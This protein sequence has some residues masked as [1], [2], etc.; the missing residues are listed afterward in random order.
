M[1]SIMCVF[2]HLQI[3]AITKQIFAH[4]TYTGSPLVCAWLL[5]YRVLLRLKDLLHIFQVHG[6]PFVCVR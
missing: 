6:Q 1:V 4:V 2:I 3:T 5:A